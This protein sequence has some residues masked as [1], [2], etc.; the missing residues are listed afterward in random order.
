MIS[1]ERIP[2]TFWT[3]QEE[4]SLFGGAILLGLPAGVLFDVFRV[5][6]RAVR[7]PVLAVAAEDILWLLGVTALLLCYASAC[8]KGVFRAY[9]A[10]GCLIGFVLYE[11][12]LGGPAV[13]LLD[14]VLRV[15]LAP[16]RRFQQSAGAI[17]TK[18]RNA[19]VRIAKKHCRGQKIG[20]NRLQ[21]PTKLVYNRIMHKQKGSTYGKD[22]T[23]CRSS[24]ARR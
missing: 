20:Q 14:T 17:C 21:E 19:F 24:S 9:Y 2:D 11:T 4:L 8:A 6:R 13:R 18:M 1:A 5:M 15:V 22:K 12:T 3:T 10:A 23:S 16:F 7:H